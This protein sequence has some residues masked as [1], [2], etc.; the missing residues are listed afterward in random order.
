[1]PRCGRL[2][3]YIQEIAESPRAEKLSF[4]PPFLILILEFVLLQH[5][6]TIQEG[7]IIILTSILL[8]ISV[9][10]LFLVANEI[11]DHYQR[12]N[13]ERILTIKLDDFIIK[14][15][16]ENLKKIVEGFLEYNPIYK[17]IIDKVYRISCQILE[18]HKQEIIEEEITNHLKKFILKEKKLTVD[19]TLDKF[20]KKYPKYKKYR[21]II[22]EKTC[23]LKIKIK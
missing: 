17:N 18:T 3:T 5:A 9:I 15:R 1:M 8:I 2:R 19:E 7:Y 11:H 14:R 20:L 6:L 21:G 16:G 23:I 12:R 4:F 13:S 10:E 22:Y